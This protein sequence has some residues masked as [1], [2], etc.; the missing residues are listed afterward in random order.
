MIY[1]TQV[2]FIKEGKEAIFQEFESH[3]IPLMEKY[4]GKMLYRIRPKKENFISSNNE[5]PYEIHIITFNTE[6]ELNAFIKDDNRLNYM[7]LK[8]ASI[9]SILLVKGEKIK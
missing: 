8:E 2:I 3:A 9:K 7:H 5:L 4:G 1:I 6:K